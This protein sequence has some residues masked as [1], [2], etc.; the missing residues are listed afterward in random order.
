MAGVISS[1]VLLSV[2]YSTPIFIFVK[3]KSRPSAFAEGG[4]TFCHKIETS[5]GK[6]WQVR[7]I[8]I[9]RLLGSVH[10]QP[11]RGPDRLV[12]TRAQVYWRPAAQMPSRM[13]EEVFIVAW[14]FEGPAL[15]CWRT[16]APY[17]FSPMVAVVRDRHSASF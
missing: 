17:R 7:E 16:E 11:D 8:C 1:P 13:A 10:G 14:I 15:L 6:G 5:V 9:L 2:Q 4:L 3:L 12:R